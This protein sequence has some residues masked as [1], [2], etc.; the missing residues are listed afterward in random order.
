MISGT[1]A[2]ADSGV[3]LEVQVVDIASGLLE[4]SERVQGREEQLVELQNRVVI[5]VMRALSVTL[6]AD[7]V[8][9]ILAKRTNDTLDSYKLLT[10]T[11]EGA[12]EEGGERKPEAHGGRS[13]LFPWPAAAYAEEVNPEEAAVRKLL[14]RYRAALEAKDLDQLATIQAPLSEGQ[15]GALRRYF[16]NAESLKV[17]FTNLDILFE[18]DEALATFTRSDVFKDARSGREMHLDVRMSSVL[19]KQEGGWKIRALKKPS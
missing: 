17:Q 18:G 11:L 6:A 12:G 8:K 19:A 3:A 10:E 14:E 7:D 5:N 2:S 16:E 13:W 4:D 9:K 15:R 1:I